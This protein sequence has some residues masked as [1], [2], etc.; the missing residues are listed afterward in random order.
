MSFA[1]NLSLYTLL[2]FGIIA[3]PG[4]DMLYVMTNG[5]TGGRR[6][7]FAATA[8]IMLGG[9]VHTLWGAV[10]VRALLALSQTAFQ[11]MLFVGAAYLGWIG[12][13]LIR[14]AITVEAPDRGT[15]RSAWAA[16]RQGAITCLLN[17]KAYA[18]MFTVFPQFVKPQLGP[19]WMQALAMGIVTALMQLL[20]Y[21]SLGL[22]AAAG[23]G[24]LV[25]NPA[26]TIRV[27]KAAGWLFV[28]I[29]LLTAWEGVQA[30]STQ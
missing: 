20:I 15:P 3:V 19:V 6:A 25:T 11:I 13:T 29:A 22:L 9:A 21:G 27:G 30:V 28:A 1:E 4:M 18:F 12:Y 23:R 2:V 10:S 17:P 24:R 8:G 26:L 5:L 14:S 16:F 7:A